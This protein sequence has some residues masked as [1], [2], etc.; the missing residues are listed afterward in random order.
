MRA[1]R[2][3]DVIR[4]GQRETLMS[5]FAMLDLLRSRIGNGFDFR[6]HATQ[7]SIPLAHCGEVLYSRNRY[8]GLALRRRRCRSDLFDFASAPPLLKINE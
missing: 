4:A 6:Y 2:K 1:T 8:T 7:G 3:E 5:I